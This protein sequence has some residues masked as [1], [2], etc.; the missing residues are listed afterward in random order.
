MGWVPWEADSKM[1]TH[2]HR[3]C[4]GVSLWLLPVEGMGW[5]GTEQREKLGCHHVPMRAPVKSTGPLKLGW[6]FKSQ[7]KAGPVIGQGCPGGMTLDEAALF[8]WKFQKRLTRSSTRSYLLRWGTKGDLGTHHSIPHG[9]QSY[10]FPDGLM[11]VP[12]PL[13][14]GA[15]K[16][17]HLSYI[18]LYWYVWQVFLGL[19][20]DS[21]VLT[22]YLFAKSCVNCIKTQCSGFTVCYMGW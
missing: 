17:S 12:A 4:Q 8:S 21:L 19:V 10:V 18:R 6:I 15:K 9:I 22:T 14:N 7:T 20:P 3:F 1:K 2:T 16:K 5:R 13:W 11:V